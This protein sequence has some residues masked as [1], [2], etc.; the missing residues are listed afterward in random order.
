M[1]SILKNNLYLNIL[2][3]VLDTSD[4]LEIITNKKNEIIYV[5]PSAEKLTGYSSS[6]WIKDQ[7][8]KESLADWQSMLSE[9]QMGNQGDKNKQLVQLTIKSGEIRNFYI[10]T[11]ELQNLK[12]GKEGRH[13]RLKP[14]T[15]CETGDLVHENNNNSLA[16]KQL[17]IVTEKNPI[18]I[19]FTD[20]NG[21]I[22]YVNDTLIKN[23]G[24]SREELIGGNPR[25]L[26]SGYHSAEFYRDLW[27]T[28]LAG[29]V[30]RGII[31]N[32]KKNGEFYWELAVM[33]P[34]LNDKGEILSIIGMKEDITE[35]TE[36]KL[37][38]EEYKNQL[39]AEVVNRTKELLEAK[40]K[41]EESD[42][43]KSA[44]LANLSHEIRTPLN[45]IIGFTQMLTNPQ[46]R[47]DNIKKY[48]KYIQ[49]SSKQLITT[50]EDIIDISKIKTGQAELNSAS[51]SVKDI[52]FDIYYDYS[53]IALEKKLKLHL[54]VNPE[55]SDK[56]ITADEIRLK[57]IL[58]NLLSNAFKFTHQGVI[59]FGCYPGKNMK[60]TGS[61]LNGQQVF[62][63]T[64][65]SDNDRDSVSEIHFFVKDTGIGIPKDE[66]KYIFD[67]FRQIDYDNQ[68]MYG[69]L[70][71][72]LSISK[73]YVEIMGGSI[74]FDS[75]PDKGTTFHFKIPVVP[76]N[77]QMKVA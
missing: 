37:A 1:F 4:Y 28:I 34:I 5:S 30:W 56:I 75:E 31:R 18:G 71:V 52:L 65:D 3:Q 62:K 8:L 42:R 74:W 22:E 61:G 41:A 73:A 25:I 36:A 24:Y 53:K 27:D 64:A 15:Y 40:E 21:I 77:R 20:K 32:K 48:L 2:H 19:V 14:Y 67:S 66:Q 33:S 55:C 59:T 6:E 57:Q 44:F 13:Y 70:G 35:Q 7:T 9:Q 50:V 12:K 49:D 17:A 76:S 47:N 11:Q 72:G 46:S 45:G 39:E 29:K 38:L 58:G 51:L 16:L 43:L 69:G 10:T 54:E 26:K 23:S 63:D 68:R 60:N